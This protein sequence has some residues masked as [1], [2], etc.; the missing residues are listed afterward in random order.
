M[1][2]VRGRACCN[3]ARQAARDDCI[4]ARATYAELR[5]G[6]AKRIDPAGTLQ[7][8]PAAQ[9]GLAKTALRLLR[10]IALPHRVD[11]RSLGRVDEHHRI[12]TDGSLFHG[13]VP[14]NTYSSCALTSV[15]S[16]TIFA[17]ANTPLAR[18]RD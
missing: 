2:G 6:Q 12:G 1:C 5:A 9:A 8:V 11:M 15:A 14:P 4:R 10:V 17:S 13:Y 7:A 3:V 18:T 16:R